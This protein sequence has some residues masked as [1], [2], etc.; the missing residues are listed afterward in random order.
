MD[1]QQ[2]DRPLDGSRNGSGDTVHSERHEGSQGDFVTTAHGSYVWKR[3]F[4][5]TGST[6]YHDAADSAVAWLRGKIA[7]IEGAPSSYTTQDKAML[8]AGLGEAGAGPSDPD[9]TRMRVLLAAAQLGDGSWK[10]QSSKAGGNAYAT[11][12]AVFALRSAGFDRTDP[13]LEAGRSWLLT[14]QQADGSWP[15]SNWTPSS[16]SQ[17]APSMWGALALATFPSPLATLRAAGSTIEWSAVEGAESYGLIRGS[18]ASLSDSG[19]AVDLGA[20]T[21]LASA[22][23]ATSAPDPGVPSPD[24]AYFYVF[25]IRWD[26]NHDSYGRASDGRERSPSAGDCGP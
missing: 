14:N 9:V 23:G 17:V 20:V 25:R 16:P 11:G 5:R 24:S 18:V 8:M 26:Q 15:A 21:C 7:A 12:L 6:A 13:V 19:G 3:A 1:Q 2:L 22:T 4:E 10:I